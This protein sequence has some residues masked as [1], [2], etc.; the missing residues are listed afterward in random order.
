MRRNGYL[1]NLLA[2]FWRDMTLRKSLNSPK[3]KVKIAFAL[4]A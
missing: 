2:L 1:K 3:T 4:S